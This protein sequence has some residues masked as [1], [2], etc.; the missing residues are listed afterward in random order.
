MFAT[1]SES[2]DCTRW[3]RSGAANPYADFAEA[4]L[5]AF[6]VRVEV[7]EKKARH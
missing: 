7:A 3:S 1:N 6:A 5:G 2:N 4:S